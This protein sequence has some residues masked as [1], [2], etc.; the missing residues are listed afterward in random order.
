MLHE[1]RVYYAVPGRLPD[2]ER[3]FID[4]TLGL[5]ERHGIT[6]VGFWTCYLGASNNTLRYLLTWPD[7]A[8]REQRWGAFASDPDWLAAKAASEADGP[9]V[10]HITSEIW[11]P[12]SYSALQ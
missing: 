6:Q 8:T 7:L 9:L 11:K 12:T 10:D 1:Y 5:F 3:R 4:H 2:L